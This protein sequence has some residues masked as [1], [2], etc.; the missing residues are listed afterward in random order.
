M[1]AARYIEA[2]R[3]AELVRRTGR[4]AQ[5]HGLLLEAE[6][7]DALIG[8][9]CTVRS[10]ATGV[11]VQA[12][13]VGLRNGRVLLMPYGELRGV[14]LGS[15]VVALGQPLR[16]PA[17]PAFLGRVIDA[18][19]APLDGRPAPPARAMLSLRKDPI[20][21][22]SR[23]PITSV[24]ETGVRA[25]DALLTLGRG[26]RTGI[27]AGAG[28]GKSTLL[29]MLAR[30]L[31]ADVIVL[32][33]VGERGREVREFIENTLGAAGLARSVVVASTSE[34][35][36][37]VRV[38][39]AYAATAIAEHFRDQGAEVA[40]IMDSVTRFAMAQR[41]IGLAI[42]EPPTARGYT[43]SVFASLP[44]LLERCGTSPVGSITAFYTVLVEGDDLAADPVGDAVRAVL[45]GHIVLSREL[46][47]QCHFPAIDVL[48]SLS[49]LMPALTTTAE[50][51]VIRRAVGVLHRQHKSRDLV[52]LGA[53]QA[54]SN[55]E[56][57][58]ALHLA[59]QLERFLRQDIGQAVPRAQSLQLLAA[60]LKEQ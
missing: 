19:G 58:R 59:P 43:P 50:H 60:I 47:E 57:D 24:L 20:N 54:G 55:P 35:P 17:G 52:E 49:R 32:A 33:L 8:E 48:R 21:P 38:N 29:A 5:C 25:I 42:G 40:L 4:I 44:L 9:V 14:G 7:P 10:R 45:D 41:E 56:L 31:K 13:V 11:P 22:L 26:Q 12:E 30:N 37:L 1:N 51:E 34:Q 46:A 18:F 28:V 23:P 6:G 36:A 53:Y 3:R 15:E 2:V 16:V 39:T 27:F